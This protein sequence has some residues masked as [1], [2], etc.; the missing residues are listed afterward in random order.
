M[1]T[2]GMSGILILVLIAYWFISR[3]VWPPA[4]FIVALIFCVGARALEGF[5]GRRRVS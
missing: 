2:L 3:V 1:T 5:D 4:V